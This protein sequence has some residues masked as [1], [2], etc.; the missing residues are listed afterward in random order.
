MDDHILPGVSAGGKRLPVESA[1]RS[2]ALCGSGL[3]VRVQYLILKGCDRVLCRIKHRGFRRVC[4]LMSPFFPRDNSA[5]AELHGRRIRVFLNDDYWVKYAL[6]GCTYEMEVAN[7][8]DQLLDRRAVFLDCGANIGYWSVYAG[9]KV[10]S[11]DRVL[12]VEPSESTF[13]RLAENSQLNCRSFSVVRKAVYSRSGESLQFRVDAAH[14]DSNSII[15]DGVAGRVEP[16]DS[17]TIDDLFESLSISEDAVSNIVVK[18]DVEGAER[19]AFQ[20]AQRLINRGAVFIYEDHGCDPTCASTDFALRSGLEVYFLQTEM[21][22]IQILDL[23]QLAALKT[24][25]T[26]GYN[27]V[28]ARPDSVAMTRLIASL[29]GRIGNEVSV[30][31]Y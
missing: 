23:K 13:A 8:L 10:G 15:H 26:K 28:G 25:S 2:V 31:A 27:L 19:E 11:R 1:M 17:V 20:G 14:H 21:E 4:H 6:F 30:E 9:K 18:L 16:V 12:A 29:T 7:V 5:I 22:P 3:S 24:C